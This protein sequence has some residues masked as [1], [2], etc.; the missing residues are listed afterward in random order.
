MEDAHVISM[1]DP[2]I[3]KEENQVKGVTA[4]AKGTTEVEE[5]PKI[6]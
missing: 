2:N 4:M 3:E 1:P 6:T 5:N